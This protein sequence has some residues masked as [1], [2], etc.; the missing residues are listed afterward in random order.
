MVSISNKITIGKQIETLAIIYLQKQ[1]LC[2]LDKNFRSK[3]G[4]IDLIFQDMLSKQIVFV[5]VRYRKSIFFGDPAETVTKTK[6]R[7]IIHTANYYLNNK[8]Y[9]QSIY[10]RFDIIAC[11]GTLDSIKINWIQGA[12]Y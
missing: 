2:F 6:Q 3:F 8:F 9:N 1:N 12:F 5:E 7:K 11:T 4:E 10:F